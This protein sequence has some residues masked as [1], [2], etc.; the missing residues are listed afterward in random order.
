MSGCLAPSLLGPP[1]LDMAGVVA[2]LKWLGLSP[3]EPEDRQELL[4]RLRLIHQVRV[5]RQA[6][7]KTATEDQDSDG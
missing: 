2:V 7:K 5:E 6:K 4:I 3:A 1:A